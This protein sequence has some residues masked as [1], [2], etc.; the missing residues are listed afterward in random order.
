[1]NTVTQK[2]HQF[3]E[4][5]FAPVDIAPLIYFRIGF[6]LIMVWEVYRYSTKGWIRSY[7]I[8]PSYW[9]TYHGFDWVHPWPGDG[10]YIHFAVI[11]ICAVALL[12]GLFY[13]LSALA[14]AL[15]FTYIFLLDQTR[16]LNHFYLVSLVGFIM[17]VIPANR[18]L[19]IDAWTMKRI[20]SQTAPRWSLWLLRLP[21]CIA[22]SY[23][24]IAKLNAD[25]L[26]GQ[27]MKQWLANRTD[28]PVIGSMFN[29]PYAGVLFSYGG[30]AIDLL[31]V[32]LLLW[33]RTRYLA[34]AVSTFFHLMN[35]RM[36]SI[37][38]F[39]WFMIFATMLFL[40]PET[41]RFGWLTK[42]L[43]KIRLGT[44]ASNRKRAP[45]AESAGYTPPPLRNQYLLISVLGI[46]VAWQLLTPLRHF[47]YPGY[48]SWTEE[49]QYFSWH[50]KL[51]DKEGSVYFYGTDPSTGLTWE[52]DPQFYLNNRQY[53]EMA[54]HPEMIHRFAL[55]LEERHRAEGFEDIEVRVWSPTELNGRHEQLL[56]DPTVDLTEQPLDI[57]K[58]SWILPL[59]QPLFNPAPDPSV[60]IGAR[61]GGLILVNMVETAFPLNR[62]RLGE[63]ALA[64][65]GETWGLDML[66][67]LSCVFAYTESTIEQP[68]QAVCNEV[69]TTA[70]A[71]APFWQAPFIVY[72]DNEPVETCADDTC[73]VTAR[74]PRIETAASP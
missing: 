62:L 65:T 7:Y 10:M 70:L 68:I 72:Y 27:P 23:G 73:L 55:Y 38:I 35:A 29:E 18:A 6:A 33:K 21:I 63:G 54:G 13:R 66:P 1:M 4:R 40:E 71:V 67:P 12:I 17:V 61:D 25:W 14:F 51:R 74:P 24:G 42:R 52:I 32:P 56:I 39:P 28:F 5:L 48:S 41:L 47:L 45:Q 43:P 3:R 19:S 64:L 69:G 36:F 37:G 15:G 26:Q 58:K 8:N 34:I 20:R 11:T 16:Y 30:L 31:M 59:Q 60:M 2:F 9:F 50:M 57:F 46:F 53:G 44:A 49:G 22:Y